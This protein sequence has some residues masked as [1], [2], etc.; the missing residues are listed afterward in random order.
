M[1]DD[2]EPNAADDDAL[3]RGPSIVQP[4]DDLWAVVRTAP[5]PEHAPEPLAAF[6]VRRGGDWALT[7]DVVAFGHSDIIADYLA[8]RDGWTSTRS[9]TTPANLARLASWFAR[10]ESCRV[11]ESVV[12]DLD[13]G[14]DAEIPF[15][16][17]PELSDELSRLRRRLAD[18][19]G[20]GY[21]IVDASPGTTRAGLVRSWPSFGE[22]ET[23]SARRD[24]RIELVPTIGLI[25]RV[26]PGEPPVAPLGTAEATEDGWRITGGDRR[27]E[28]GRREAQPLAWIVPGSIHW[29]VRRIP[30]AVVWAALLAGMD[31][32]VEAA[33]RHRA[34]ITV[35][36][37]RPIAPV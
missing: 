10:S 6:V 37:Q 3:P 7:A 27:V 31:A 19:D 33:L 17:V 32:S 11:L 26:G 16:M 24:V 18:D 34:A 4:A 13:V 25:V 12:A 9:L 35:T 21:G 28:L 36:R 8:W 23:I 1:N 14:D 2:S 5:P 22:P 15:S 29:R 20:F 30:N